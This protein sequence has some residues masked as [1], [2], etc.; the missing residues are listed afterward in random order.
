M[1]SSLKYRADIVNDSAADVVVNEA[2]MLIA[3]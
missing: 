3:H 2:Y 1:N